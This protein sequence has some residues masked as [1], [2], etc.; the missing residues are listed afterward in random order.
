VRP[1]LCLFSV[2][3]EDES[4]NQVLRVRLEAGMQKMLRKISKRAE[5]PLEK[6]T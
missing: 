4:K 6:T 5:K 1:S 3:P 2:R